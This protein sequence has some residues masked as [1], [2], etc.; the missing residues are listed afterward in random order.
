MNLRRS[1]LF[2]IMLLLFHRAEPMR[3]SASR[4][5]IHGGKMQQNV[6][7]ISSREPASLIIE[8]SQIMLDFISSKRHWSVSM[9]KCNSSWFTRYGNDAFL[10][11]VQCEGDQ[12]DESH[13]KWTQ[14]SFKALF[15]DGYLY[16]VRNHYVMCHDMFSNQINW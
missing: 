8:V 1:V 11:S 14:F 13:I 9:C 15:T 6:L 16:E 12:Q 4:R 5:L 3:I 10:Y 7:C 2:H